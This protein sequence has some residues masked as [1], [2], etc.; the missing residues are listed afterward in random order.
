MQAQPVLFYDFDWRCLYSWQKACYEPTEHETS[1]VKLLNFGFLSEMLEACVKVLFELFLDKFL[2]KLKK[3]SP[4]IVVSETVVED[5]E[6]FMYP[7]TYHHSLILNLEEEAHKAWSDKVTP[8]DTHMQ[9]F[10][11]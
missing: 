3:P 7:Q 11:L 6:Y 1:E 5:S 8:Y 10:T 2:D 9:S 4:V